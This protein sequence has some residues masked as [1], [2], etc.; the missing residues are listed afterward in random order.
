[1]AERRMAEIVC[2]ADRLGQ[3]LVEPQRTG[4]RPADL[5][6][7]QRMRQPCSV[8]ITFVVDEDLRLVHEPPEGRRVDDAIAIAL[9]L[10]AVGRRRLRESPA[11]A[12]RLV[13]SIG[14]QAVVHQATFPTSSSRRPAS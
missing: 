7:L 1:M 5:R 10:A 12:A 3:R 2:Q 6:H 4:D 9:V 11:A 8:E 13:G 14:C